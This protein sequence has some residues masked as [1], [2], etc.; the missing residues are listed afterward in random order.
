MTQDPHNAAAAQAD[1]EDA[2]ESIV[3][4]VPF[5]IPAFGAAMIFL[6]AFIAVSMG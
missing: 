4:V 6:L 2:V 1:S 5:V 3:S